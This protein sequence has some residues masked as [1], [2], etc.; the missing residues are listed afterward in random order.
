MSLLMGWS[1]WKVPET[2]TQLAR[3]VLGDDPR[4]AWLFEKGWEKILDSLGQISDPQTIRK[5]A[6]EITGRATSKLLVLQWISGRHENAD[7]R[8]RLQCDLWA[9]LAEHHEN[10]PALTAAGIEDVLRRVLNDIEALSRPPL[11]SAVH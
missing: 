5:T 6:E 3:K 4:F 10:H 8:D 2:P 9:F 7:P 1:R 11:P